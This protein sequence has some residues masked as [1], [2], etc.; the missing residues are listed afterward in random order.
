[1]I[2]LWE[3]SGAQRY[4]VKPYSIALAVS[5]VGAVILFTGGGIVV[6]RRLENL[7]FVIIR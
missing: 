7:I 2:A 4:L 6:G 1:M 5:V 3:S